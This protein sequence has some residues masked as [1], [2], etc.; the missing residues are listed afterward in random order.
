V[1]AAGEWQ[2]IERAADNAVDFEVG[3]HGGIAN[4]INTFNV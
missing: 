3:L 2:L 1:K 4:Y